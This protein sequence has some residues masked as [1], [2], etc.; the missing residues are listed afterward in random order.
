MQ[1]LSNNIA[2]AEALKKKR[3]LLESFCGAEKINQITQSTLEQLRSN[4]ITP[5]IARDLLEFISEIYS[6]E[7]KFPQ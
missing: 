1:Q 3:A 5:A 7:H 6:L 2:T 4:M